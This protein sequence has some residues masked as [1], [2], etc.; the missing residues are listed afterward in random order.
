MENI[1]PNFKYYIVPSE[2]GVDFISEGNIAITDN[3]PAVAW[4]LNECT[5][6]NVNFDVVQNHTVYS[7]NGGVLAEYSERYTTLYTDFAYTLPDGVKAYKVKS[8]SDKGVAVRE[9]ITGT[10]PAQTPVMLIN[11]DNANSTKALVLSTDD[12]TPVTGNL[13][14]GADELINQYQL[15]TSQVESLFNMAKDVLGETAYN[16]YL[17]KY[18]HLMLT[19]AGTVNNKYFFGLSAEDVEKCVVKNEN[20]EEDCVIRSLS[21]GDEKVGFYDNW[22]AGANQA[23]LI[24]SLNPVKLWLVGD[25]NRDGS[26][27]IAD[28]TALVNIILGK[29]TYPADNDK[30]DFEAANV[31]G[32]EIISISDVTKLVNMIL[33]KE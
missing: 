15:K 17:S 5:E 18:E 16:E 20:N 23:F 27:S 2:S 22:T 6:F 33:G 14:V 32:D 30:Y 21:T 24:S 25:V 3:D 8:I 13:L 9:E 31:N 10:I 12:G 26:I 1:Q 19:N 11:T 4:T 29:A 28:V 7:T